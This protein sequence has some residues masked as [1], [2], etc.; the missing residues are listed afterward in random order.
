[1]KLIFLLINSY[2]LL[3]ALEIQK[4]KVYDKNSHEVIGWAMSEKLDGIRAYWDGKNL[5]SKNSNQIHAPKWFISQLPPF[6]IDGELWTKRAD[7]ENIQNIVLDKNP[8]KKWEEIT[9]NI[10]EVPN[11]KGDFFQR[12][13]VLEKWLLENNSKNIKII[14]QTIC[15]NKNHLNE[16]LDTLVSKNAEGIIIKNPK[17]DY[18]VGRSSNVLKVKKFYDSEGLVIGHNYNEKN[19]FKSLK[20]KLENGVIFNLGGGFSNLQRKTPPKLNDIVTFKYYDFTKY[21]KPKF[22]SFLRVRKKE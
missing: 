14:P 22:A 5:L 4:A 12:L 2:I 16:Y 17:I 10:F 19:E 21:G 13:N 8:S 18:F 20:I 11:Q 1:M 9:Y 6:E 15:K 7:F 3:F